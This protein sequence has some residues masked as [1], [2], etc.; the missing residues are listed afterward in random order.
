MAS[1]IKGTT[2]T[3]RFTFRDVDPTRIVTTAL[4]IKQNKELVIERDLTTATVSESD[5]SISYKLSQE[6][7][8]SFSVGKVAVMHNWVL[9]DGTRGASK[10]AVI[11]IEDNHKDEVMM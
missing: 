7:T 9:D 2:P 5:S 3:M 11:T 10:E 1:I 4:T 8:L 6:E